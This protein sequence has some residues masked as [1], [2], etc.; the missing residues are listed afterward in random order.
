M[1]TCVVEV[2]IVKAKDMRGQVGGLRETEVQLEITS[3]RFE[4]V[5][6]ANCIYEFRK[7]YLYLILLRP[8]QQPC[9]YF[10]SA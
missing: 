6:C 2:D 5:S 7:T 4:I 3:M 9:R 8:I 1:I 10:S